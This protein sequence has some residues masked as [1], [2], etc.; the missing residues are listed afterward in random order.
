MILRLD[1][2]HFVLII[3][4]GYCTADATNQSRQHH[5]EPKTHV[6]P[7]ECREALASDLFE[8]HFCVASQSSLSNLFVMSTHAGE[9]GAWL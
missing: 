5:Y 3:L 7:F 9:I 4:L 6:T 2:Q 8:S 1:L